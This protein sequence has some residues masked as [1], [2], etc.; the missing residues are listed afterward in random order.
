LLLSAL[1]QKV[2]ELAQ[3]IGQGSTGNGNAGGFGVGGFGV[4]GFGRRGGGGGGGGGDEGLAQKGEA[5]LALLAEL[6]IT[7]QSYSQ[8]LQALIMD[9]SGCRQ[10]RKQA[11]KKN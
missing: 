11:R 8:Y 4:G 9:V 5:F 6:D 7:P 1:Y 3:S 2:M 10:C